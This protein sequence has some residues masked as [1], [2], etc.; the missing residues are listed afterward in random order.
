MR[1]NVVLDGFGSLME[2]SFDET[3]LRK[4]DL[5]SKGLFADRRHLDDY[6][7]HLPGPERS[8]A[9]PTWQSDAR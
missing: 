7:L 4:L 3:T 5:R 8:S 6:Q 2:Q 9:R 1:R